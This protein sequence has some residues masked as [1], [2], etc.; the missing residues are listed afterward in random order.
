MI[1]DTIKAHPI[2]TVG[3]V[4][5]ALLVLFMIMSGGSS[6]GSSSASSNGGLDPNAALQAATSLQTAE[7]KSGTDLAVAQLGYKSHLDDINANQNLY[8]LSSNADLLGKYSDNDTTLKVAGINAG[9]DTKKIDAMTAIQIA[10]FGHDSDIASINAGVDL[11]GIIANRDININNTNA[12]LDISR[13]NNATTLGVAGIN[14]DTT[15]GL[16]NTNANIN[17]SNR[18]AETAQAG[19]KS[20]GGILSS[21]LGFLF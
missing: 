20:A 10:S 16:A 1:T 15:L 4:G 18:K 2:A 9:V 19:I 3:V 8:T 14:S 7:L 13:S 12:L 5:V 21:V 17:A 11:A 6:G